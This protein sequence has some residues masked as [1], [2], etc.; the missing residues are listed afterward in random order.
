MHT[1]IHVSIHT[2]VCMHTF[3]FV[4]IIILTTMKKRRKLEE[5]QLNNSPTSDQ[6]PHTVGAALKFTQGSLNRPQTQRR[7]CCTYDG[8]HVAA[9]GGGHQRAQVRLPV[10]AHGGRALGDAAW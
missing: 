9:L 5:K 7:R 6:S 10:H 4:T 3:V 2:Y 1:C 8:G